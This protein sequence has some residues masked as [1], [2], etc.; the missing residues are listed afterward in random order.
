MVSALRQYP[1]SISVR[2]RRP[3]YN[4][5]DFFNVFK[6]AYHA[7]TRCMAFI[8]ILPQDM[9]IIFEPIWL[10]TSLNERPAACNLYMSNYC[11]SRVR[12]PTL[13]HFV[14]SF[15]TFIFFLHLS[16]VFFNRSSLYLTVRWLYIFGIW[17]ILYR[18]HR[19]W[20]ILS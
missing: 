17:E 2:L 16:R 20:K 10:V 19:T 6:F 14:I 3:V 18:F 11:I 8:S 9:V 1:S 7:Y 5:F 4:F 15:K 12:L 13:S